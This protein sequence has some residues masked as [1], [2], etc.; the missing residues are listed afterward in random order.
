VEE[1][2]DLAHG[3][4]GTTGCKRWKVGQFKFEKGRIET[5]Q[6]VSELLTIADVA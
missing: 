4:N 5:N 1:F 2:E 6:S 3:V